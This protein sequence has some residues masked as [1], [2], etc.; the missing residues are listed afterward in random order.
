MPNS[1]LDLLS[2]R[3]ERFAPSEQN[4]IR[5]VLDGK[6]GVRGVNVE[7]ERQTGERKAPNGQDYHVKIRASTTGVARDMG[8][9]P[10]EAWQKGGLA[11]F[12]RNPIIL[13]FH[14]H[15]Q[16]IGISVHTE[17]N[18]TTRSLDQYWLFHEESDISRLMRKLYERG[19]M[20]AASVGFLVKDF[21]ILDES[22]EKQIQKEMG[23]SDPIFWRALDAELLETS[24][25]PVP[26]DANAL[27]LEH[28]I[29]NAR[30]VDIDVRELADRTNFRSTQM[31][32]DN[33]DSNAEG[34]Q[35]PVVEP[36]VEPTPPAPTP[37]VSEERFAALEAQVNELKE[38]LD[39]PAPTVTETPATEEFTEEL[40]QLS[41]EKREGESD[42]DALNRY[43]DEIAAN[44]GA[45][46]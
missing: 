38:R 44:N 6:V 31:P 18:A 22:E 15:T 28:A 41:I 36:V 33:K 10:M 43:I 16:P 3:L 9:I 30:A 29:A 25:V 40:V 12:S 46:Q 27:V 45:T 19:F 2:A 17:L 34:T 26:S 5:E 20:R 1:K 4:Y 35:E 8:I 13:A 11:N 14:D 42:E 32:N 7:V 39:T 24:A 23:I 21:Q 37:S